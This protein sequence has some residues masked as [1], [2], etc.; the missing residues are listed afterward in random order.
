MD[1]C[2]LE[3]DRWTARDGAGQTDPIRPC[4]T[5]IPVTSGDLADDGCVAVRTR[6]FWRQQYPAIDGQRDGLLQCRVAYVVE[7]IASHHVSLRQTM[8]LSAGRRLVGREQGG[9]K[10]SKMV[11]SSISYSSPSS[12]RSVGR[13]REAAIAAP[14]RFMIQQPPWAS[15]ASQL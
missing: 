8:G 12:S 15:G 2:A 14:K 7:L 11:V 5:R 9:S 6:R 13:R 10:Q 3:V 1:D 4:I